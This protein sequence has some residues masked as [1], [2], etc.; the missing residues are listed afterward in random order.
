M[1][2]K[3]TE[4]QHGKDVS[5]LQKK[6]LRMEQAKLPSEVKIYCELGKLKMLL[7]VTHLGI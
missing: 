1:N 6:A 4:N 3:T 5:L 7:F 2:F